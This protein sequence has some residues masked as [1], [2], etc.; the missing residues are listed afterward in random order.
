MGQGFYA[1]FNKFSDMTGVFD[2]TTSSFSDTDPFEDSSDTDPTGLETDIDALEDAN[3]FEPDDE[4]TETFEDLD[5][6]DIEVGE[7]F[8]ED[9]INEV[10]MDFD[11]GEIEPDWDP[12]DNLSPA[13][14]ATGT[15]HEDE[16]ADTDLDDEPFDEV[17]ET[18]PQEEILQEDNII[19]DDEISQLEETGFDEPLFYPEDDDTDQDLTNDAVEDILDVDHLDD[20]TD[21][22]ADEIGRQGEF[23]TGAADWIA[24]LEDFTDFTES[25]TSSFHEVSD[26]YEITDGYDPPDQDNLMDNMIE[27]PNLVDDV[28]ASVFPDPVNDPFSWFDSFAEF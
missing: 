20:T 25:D 23:I 12:A 21:N 22:A 19:Q 10:D 17:S 13:D 11:P 28:F 18:S 26:G 24:G 16:T 15:S 9:Q 6:D 27:L 5:D 2:G 8:S 1:S 4:S 3:P 14:E 7:D